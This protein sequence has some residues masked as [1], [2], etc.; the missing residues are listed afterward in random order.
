MYHTSSGTVEL[1]ILSSYAKHSTVLYISTPQRVL[2]R[3]TVNGRWIV[4]GLALGSTDLRR[5]WLSFGL[6][7]ECE[8]RRPSVPV[9]DPSIAL[10]V[11][12]LDP[13]RAWQLPG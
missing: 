4:A 10:R 12:P 6:S 9:V 13:E 11:P 8:T 1:V 3:R 2:E 7:V 5:R